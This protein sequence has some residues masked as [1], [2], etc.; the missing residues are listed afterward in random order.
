MHTELYNFMIYTS[1]FDI[2]LAKSNHDKK[3]KRAL[4]LEKYGATEFYDPDDIDHGNINNIG[5][6]NVLFFDVGIEELIE[7]RK[8]LETFD[9]HL[10][11]L[12]VVL[13]THTSLNPL[14]PF[15]LKCSLNRSLI[16]KNILKY[17]ENELYENEFEVR[18][19][20][21][22][23]KKLIGEEMN[24][25]MKIVQV[26]NIKNETEAIIELFKVDENS[27]K[28]DIIDLITNEIIK[29]K[30]EKVKKNLE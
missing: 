4:V 21:L 13:P 25:F 5:Y 18:F 2:V 30:N 22:F 16:Q 27:N 10:R 7:Y 29:P 15:A 28:I 19:R 12:I 9:G 23:N 3:W 26:E 11:D 14:A 20:D 8:T 1:K 24:L 6:F 17:K